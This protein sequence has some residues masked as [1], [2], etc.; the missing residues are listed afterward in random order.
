MNSVNVFVR[1]LKILLVIFSISCGIVPPKP[2]L[3][4]IEDVS[5]H[6]FPTD[7]EVPEYDLEFEDMLGY[8]A[9]SPED[10]GDIKKFL[11]KILEKLD[12]LG[13]P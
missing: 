7:P 11:K 2:T 8:I 9:T 1:H 5:A 13:Q 4:V 3:C 10:F 12:R 6:C